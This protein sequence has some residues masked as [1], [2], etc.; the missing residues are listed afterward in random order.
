MSENEASPQKGTSDFSKFRKALAT[1]PEVQAKFKPIAEEF[2]AGLSAIAKEAGF[3]IETKGR[4]GFFVFLSRFLT[5]E[6]DNA[7]LAL[8]PDEV[9]QHIPAAP[10]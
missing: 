3:S 5:E 8:V 7:G 10:R 6:A 1:D 2:F 4:D 9:K